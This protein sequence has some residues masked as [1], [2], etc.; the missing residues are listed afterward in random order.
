MG[1]CTLAAKRSAEEWVSDDWAAV[2][3]AVVDRQRELGM[4]QRQLSERADVAKA[5]LQEIRRNT[6]QR[7]RS[8]RTLEAISEA[9]GWHRGHLT[10]VLRGYP[11]PK[12][13]DPV[14]IS[15]K[16][17]PSRLTVIEHEL[18]QLNERVESTNMR[19]N[20]MTTDI[21]ATLKR[22]ADALQRPNS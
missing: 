6:V 20:E 2:S 11:P 19:L 10:A 12:P 13:G 21:M 5:T 9:L 16:D 17:V 8:E 3:R 14:V 7:D 18:R 1:I 4:S 22:I 15:D